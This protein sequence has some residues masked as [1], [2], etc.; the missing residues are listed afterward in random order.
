MRKWLVASWSSNSRA[1]HPQMSLSLLVKWESTWRVLPTKPV[2]QHALYWRVPS[3]VAI[4]VHISGLGHETA[5]FLLPGY[6][7]IAKP[8]NK[9]SR[10]YVYICI[11]YIYHISYISYIW[12]QHHTHNHEPISSII[13]NLPG[14]VLKCAGF[15][16]KCKKWMIIF[17]NVF[18]SPCTSNVHLWRTQVPLTRWYASTIL[19][20]DGR[21][22]G[23]WTQYTL[24]SMIIIIIIIIIMIM[25]IVTITI[26]MIL[27]IIQW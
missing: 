24:L 19:S 20:N 7:L 18:A 9:D 10:S 8:G 4:T 12:V 3:R 26:K 15:N 21:T 11:L 13:G 14:Y 17:G 22:D 25:M 23:R 5:A 27:M 2:R 1:L 6:Q 16:C